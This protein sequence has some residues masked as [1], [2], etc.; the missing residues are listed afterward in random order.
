MYIIQ[1]GEKHSCLITEEEAR[2]L[3]NDKVKLTEFV[4]H[5]YVNT[6]EVVRLLNQKNENTFEDLRII[7]LEKI[8]LN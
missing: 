8:K 4:H 2:G 7:S 5:D 3:I 1:W 6:E